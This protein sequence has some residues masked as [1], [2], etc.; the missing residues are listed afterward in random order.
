MQTLWLVLNT[1]SKLCSTVYHSMLSV[2]IESK[3]ACFA[4]FLKAPVISKVPV[5]TIIL[6]KV[7]VYLCKYKL[8]VFTCT[9][10][11]FQICSTLALKFCYRLTRHKSN[12]PQTFIVILWQIV[13]TTFNFLW[14]NTGGFWLGQLSGSAKLFW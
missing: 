13:P 4:F 14:L 12:K 10:S 3:K 1:Y 5:C 2:N 11:H 7:L 6:S 9:C 8:L